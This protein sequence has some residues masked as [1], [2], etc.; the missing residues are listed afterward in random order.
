MT[1]IIRKGSRG[2]DVVALQ[3]KLKLIPD[4]IF[5]PITEE[6]VRA[7]QKAQGLVPDGIVGPK[8]LSAL[9]LTTNTKSRLINKIIIH[10]SATP[11]GKNFS[12]DQIRQWH[13]AR[14]FADIGYH[15]VIYLDGSV[16]VGRP[17]E[18]V[19]AHTTGH[20]TNSIGIC[21][22][23]GL[24]ADSKSPKDTRTLQQKKALMDLVAKLRNSYP[25]ATVHG[26]NEFA[27]KA[28][29]SF[30]VQNDCDL[31]GR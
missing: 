7:F 13:L 8:T 15:Y 19:G 28:C 29:P 3:Q 4:G 30:S 23:G 27:N 11:E 21:Y 17:L 24:S 6:A 14:N 12:V 18:K 31:C 25:S 5:G 9:G 16:H 26:H 20:N 2:N 1:K 22:V 10:C